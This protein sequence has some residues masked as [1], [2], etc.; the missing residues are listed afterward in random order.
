MSMISELLRVSPLPHHHYPDNYR[1]LPNCLGHFFI[2]IYCFDYSKLQPT[3]VNLIFWHGNVPLV[4]K[5]CILWGFC[6]IKKQHLLSFG[7]CDELYQYFRA[8]VPSLGSRDILV[9]HLLEVSTT[10]RASKGF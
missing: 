9:L 10:S 4:S 8:M 5:A 2:Y 3:G 7:F 6:T 1:Y